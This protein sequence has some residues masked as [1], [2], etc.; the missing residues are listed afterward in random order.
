M[1]THAKS[2]KSGPTLK[3]VRGLL[4][5]DAQKGRVMYRISHDGISVRASRVP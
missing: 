4:L 1:M 3:G 5:A 2:E